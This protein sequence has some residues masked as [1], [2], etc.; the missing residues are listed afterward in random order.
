M[1]FIRIAATMTA[2][3]EL[4]RNPFFP[5]P[6]SAS[7]GSLG[8]EGRGAGSVGA[9]SVLLARRILGL[10]WNTV[11]SRRLWRSRQQNSVF[12]SYSS[13]DPAIREDVARGRFSV[14]DRYF[15][16]RSHCSVVFVDAGFSLV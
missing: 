15:V 11:S 2:T 9:L 13:P 5:I 12:S 16:R 4:P 3:T 6:S 7:T 8:E 1:F 10:L 14:S